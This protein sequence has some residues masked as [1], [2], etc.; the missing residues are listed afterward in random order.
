MLFKF[1]RA[2]TDDNYNLFS[3]GRAQILHAGF[4]DGCVAERKQRFEGAHPTR[5]AGS[6]Q[7]GSDVMHAS[8]GATFGGLPKLDTITFGIHDAVETT[9]V[10]FFDAPIDRFDAEMIAIPIANLFG[11]FGLET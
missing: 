7:Y 6:E 10:A 9:V 2:M 4:N 3:T 5:A 1:I 11:I 8:D